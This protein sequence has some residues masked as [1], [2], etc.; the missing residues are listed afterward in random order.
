M[1]THRGP[2]ACEC[3]G[4]IACRGYGDGEGNP[5]CHRHLDRNPCAIEGCARTTAA[6]RGQMANDQ[7]ICAEHWRRY[8]PPGS[9][10]R[11]LYHRHFRR[12][13]RL[14]WDAARRRS[15]W[16]FW[17]RLIARVRARA[18]DGSIDEKAI[19]ELFGWDLD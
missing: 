6:P 14:G 15:F 12:A 17:D 18:T 19:A 11:R 16:N 9:R 13:K 10:E 8:V 4:D 2:G 3:C 1:I 5:R 7:W